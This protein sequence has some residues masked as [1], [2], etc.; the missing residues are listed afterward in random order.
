MMPSGTQNVTKGHI[1]AKNQNLNLKIPP[2]FQRKRRECG[3]K[4]APLGSLFS[5]EL[6]HQMALTEVLLKYK[7]WCI[8]VDLVELKTSKILSGQLPKG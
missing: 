1:L 7:N 8:E 4:C 5:V 6:K 3:A 2:P